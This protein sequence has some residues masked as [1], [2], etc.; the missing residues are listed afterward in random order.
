MENASKALLMAAGVLMTM[1]IVMLLFFFKGRITDFYNEQGKIDDIENVE[2]FNKQ[3][4]NYD[5]KKVYGY[6]II[7]LTNMI[8]DY[9][10]RHSGAKGAQNDEK[11]NP[12]TLTVSL[13][14]S[15]KNV[16]NLW[17]DN[18][19]DPSLHLFKEGDNFQQSDT[20][21]KLVNVIT[22]GLNIEDKY[23]SAQIAAKLAKSI[24]ALIVDSK[25]TYEIE[26]IAR[27]QGVDVNKATEIL[28]K[29]SVEDY[30]R[31]INDKTERSYDDI[32]NIL[33]KDGYDGISI[34]KYYEF[35]QFKRAVFKCTSIEY[36]NDQG[37]TGRVKSMT[38][39]FDKVE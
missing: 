6:E 32:E 7:S 1:L 35:H 31:I 21:N 38:F 34:K 12:I 17:F 10:T 27:E 15:N 11:Y 29:K 24:D 39:E 19:T 8:Q 22:S 16:K 37:G 18:E 20:D 5:R 33:L 30:K 4:T 28:K 23:G 2:K 3:F 26:R 14:R 13:P 9:N 36:D 25:D